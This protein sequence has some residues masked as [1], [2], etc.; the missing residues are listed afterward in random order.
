MNLHVAFDG[1]SSLHV[2]LQADP[3]EWPLLL[4]AQ[5]LVAP[6]VDVISHAK[7][8]YLDHQPLAHEDVP[9]CKVAVVVARARQ[10]L[11]AWRG[12]MVCWLV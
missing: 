10:V 5:P 1:A 6:L 12:K 4:L 9:G 8:R 7:V 2:G 3:F 11:L